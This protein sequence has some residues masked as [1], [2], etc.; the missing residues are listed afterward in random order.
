MQTRPS[1]KDDNNP[2]RRD[3]SDCAVANETNEVEVDKEEMEKDPGR[4]SVGGGAGPGVGAINS[5]DQLLSKCDVVDKAER[6]SSPPHCHHLTLNNQQQ[7]KC[8]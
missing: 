8:K 7:K 4:R 5:W 1:L 3:R 2:R 6:H